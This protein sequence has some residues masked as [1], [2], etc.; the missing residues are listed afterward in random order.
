[1]SLESIITITFT[2]L[3]LVLGLVGYIWRNAVSRIENLEKNMQD[4]TSE[5]DVRQLLN[6]K[7]E[8]VKEDLQEIKT[9]LEH[10]LDN[11]INKK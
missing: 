6:D 10:I 2:V 7:L 4:K 9:R 8:P 3:G 11:L 1:M 5:Q